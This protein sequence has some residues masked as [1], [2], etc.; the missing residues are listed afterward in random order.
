M[1]ADF[2]SD[3]RPAESAGS[4]ACSPCRDDQL[5]GRRA[6]SVGG[7]RREVSNP[8][9]RIVAIGKTGTVNPS[10]TSVINASAEAAAAFVGGVVLA[11]LLLETQ[12]EPGT[13][14][15]LAASMAVRW[16]L[17]LA[18]AF[19]LWR[20]GAAI[21]GRPRQPMLAAVGLGTTAL[22]AGALLGWGVLTFAL[23]ALLPRVLVFVDRHFDLAMGP[24]SWRLL[25]APYDAA[26]WLQMA[27]GSFLLVPIVEE[28]FFRGYLQSRLIEA[29]GPATGIALTALFFTACHVQY[30]QPNAIAIGSL[31]GLA[32]SA[33]LLGYL[34]YQ[35][36]SIWPPLICHAL[37]NLPAKGACEIA[38]LLLMMGILLWWRRRIAVLLHGLWDTL[39]PIRGGWFA[40]G[41]TV[42][43]VVVGT[44]LVLPAWRSVFATAAAGLA[45]LGAWWQ[46]RCK[47]KDPEAESA[48]GAT[49]G[50]V[51]SP[52]A[53]RPAAPPA[54]GRPK[55]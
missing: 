26:F 31:F 23:A 34:R 29:A 16:S 36:A 4:S 10:R 44:A 17:A 25:D 9:D 48:G 35:T 18:I 21:S 11:G 24:S 54:A 47:F 1:P 15:Q 19:C 53:S 14:S 41:A 52:A 20:L 38:L 13:S 40:T 43:L 33:L 3:V 45:L 8:Q 2:R 6:A 22:S 46:R 28:L 55:W 30:L 27:V 50:Q 37:S 49:L 7:H 5:H 39:R 12:A 42:L 51:R 32:F